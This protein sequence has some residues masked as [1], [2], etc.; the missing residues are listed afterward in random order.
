MISSDCDASS[1]RSSNEARRLNAPTPSSL[2]ISLEIAGSLAVT[3]W[4][5]VAASACLMADSQDCTK[6]EVASWSL[7]KWTRRSSAASAVLTRVVD[8]IFKEGF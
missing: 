3:V 2:E 1:I 5:R 6:G 8:A 4:S 7:R